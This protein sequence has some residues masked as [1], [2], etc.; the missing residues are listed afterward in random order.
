M[1]FNLT[2]NSQFVGFLLYPV[3]NRFCKKRLK[4]IISAIISLASVLCIALICIGTAY[5][6]TFIM[7]LVLFLLLGLFG[8]A[9]F[10]VSMCMM[11][12]DRYLARTVGISYALGIL[13]QFANNNLVHSEMMEAIVLVV[14]LL[15]L[16]CMLIK[17][18]WSYCKKTNHP[19]HYRQMMKRAKLIP[20]KLK[21][22]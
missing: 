15:L 17:N 16:V 8:S 7:G 10:Y 6:T 1:I 9:V 21:R 13:L 12:T 18:D 14:F 3:L 22:E 11:K 19:L 20:R 4:I 5:T 2:N